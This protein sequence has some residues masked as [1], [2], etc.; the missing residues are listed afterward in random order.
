MINIYTY[1]Y[2]NGQEEGTI[3]ATNL[4]SQGFPGCLMS[5]EHRLLFWSKTLCVPTGWTVIL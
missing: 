3:T 4:P 1:I 5:S 2:L